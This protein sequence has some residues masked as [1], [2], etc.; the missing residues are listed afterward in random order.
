MPKFCVL[1]KHIIFFLFIIALALSIELS[2]AVPMNKLRTVDMAISNDD[3]EYHQRRIH[4]L[5]KLRHFL[6]TSN[7]EQ[8]AARRDKQNFYKQQLIREYLKAINDPNSDRLQEVKKRIKTFCNSYDDVMNSD[9]A[10][11]G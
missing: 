6:L 7:E 1:S 11:C 2:Q 8:R 5:N 9:R 3:E 10:A 4:D